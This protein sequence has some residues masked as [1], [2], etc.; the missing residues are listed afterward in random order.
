MLG[1]VLFSAFLHRTL[2]MIELDSLEGRT[3]RLAEEER[4]REE[5]GG[6]SLGAGPCSSAG[7]RRDRMLA[8]TATASER[9]GEAHA[10]A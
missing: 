10:L 3:P 8:S 9:H 4:G 7:P 6:Y 2:V 1:S 5:G